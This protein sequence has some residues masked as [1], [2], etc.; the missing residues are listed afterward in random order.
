MDTIYLRDIELLTTIGVYQWEQRI[1]QKLSL[2]LSM[3]VDCRQ[4]G[5]SDQL[6]DALDYGA[7]L[8]SVQTL[9]KAQHVAL[10]E[11]LATL[12]ADHILG[13]FPMVQSITVDLAK[14]HIFPNVPRVG[15]VLTRERRT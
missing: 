6:T 4:A 8:Q 10:L 14:I 13:N 9:V 7:V 2:N 3:T 11:K 12:I 1:E 15:V 5:Q